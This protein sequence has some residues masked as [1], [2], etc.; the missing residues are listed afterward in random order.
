MRSLLLLSVF[1]AENNR[2]I[3][4][5]TQQLQRLRNSLSVFYHD[6]VLQELCSMHSICSCLNVLSGRVPCVLL[7]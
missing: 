7:F 2:K 1:Y 4:M 5:K 6:A 3:S